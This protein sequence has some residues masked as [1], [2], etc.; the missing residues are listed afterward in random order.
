MKRWISMYSELYNHQLKHTNN[1]L[2]NLFSLMP[3]FMVTAIDLDQ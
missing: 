2:V 1:K 3:S